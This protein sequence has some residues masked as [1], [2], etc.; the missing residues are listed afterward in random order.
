MI[1]GLSLDQAVWWI[2]YVCRHK[3]ADWVKSVGEEVSFFQV[4][5]GT[6]TMYM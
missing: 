6:C 4:M 1:T 3:G 5:Y 2:E